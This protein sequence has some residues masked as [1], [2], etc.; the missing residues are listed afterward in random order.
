MNSTRPP[1]PFLEP[2]GFPQPS[3]LNPKAIT[4]QSQIANLHETIDALEKAIEEHGIVISCA[5]RPADPVPARDPEP[6]PTDPSELVAAL[7]TLTERAGACVRKLN[8]LTQ[9][10]QL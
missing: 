9:R 4:V 5:V 3:A 6:K 2:R 10:V 1:S 8:G 7:F